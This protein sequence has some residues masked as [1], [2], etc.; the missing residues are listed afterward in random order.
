MFIA[1]QP[2]LISFPLRSGEGWSWSLSEGYEYHAPGGAQTN[3]SPL[4]YHL[5]AL[6]YR[7]MQ[8]LNGQSCCVL[9]P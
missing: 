5:A 8:R 4:L 2:N 6:L 7:S 1:R 9:L 3:R